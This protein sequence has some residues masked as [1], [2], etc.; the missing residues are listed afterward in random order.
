LETDSQTQNYV[1][2][3]FFQL[4]AYFRAQREILSKTVTADE[5]WTEGKK[6][7]HGMVQPFVFPEEKG[8]SMQG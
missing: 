5:T 2:C 6:V 3:H 8:K 7:I 4:L 1:K